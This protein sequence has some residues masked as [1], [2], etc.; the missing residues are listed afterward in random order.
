M[1][2]AHLRVARPT[3]DL[4]AIIRFYRDGLGFEIID[5]F[6]DHQGFDGVMLGHADLAY[7]LEFTHQS[8][9]SVAKAP[10]KENLLVF[11]LPDQEMWVQ[12]L[13]R[14]MRLGYEPVES[15]NPYWDVQGKTFEDIDGYRVVLQG[16][17]WP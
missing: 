11:Y 13:N 2:K 15:Y 3:S 8:N 5:S 17:A 7:H 12:A 6:E 14:M 4:P 10:S 9:H 16:T 1:E